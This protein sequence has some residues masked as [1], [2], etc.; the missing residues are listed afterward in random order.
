MF[1]NYI[2]AFSVKRI[3]KKKSVNTR[4]DSGVGVIKTV[5]LLVDESYFL[6]TKAVV[7]S[8]VAQ[9]IAERNI[10]ILIYKEKVKKNRECSYPSFSAKDLNWDGSIQSQAANEFISKQFDLLINYYELDKAALL[11]VSHQSKAKFTVGFSTIDK[12]LNDLV[13]KATADDHVVFTNELFKYLKILN[14]I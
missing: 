8:L 4:S 10:E 5:G 14:K 9:G 11:V 3:L 13:I 7:A 6:A 2:K 1:L 12:Q